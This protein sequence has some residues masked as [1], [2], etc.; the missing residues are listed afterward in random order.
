M[1]TTST[2]DRERREWLTS[3][4]KEVF[5]AYAAFVSRGGGSFEQ[6]RDLFHDALIVCYEKGRLSPVAQSDKAYLF[7]TAKHLW[8]NERKVQSGKTSTGDWNAAMD[9]ADDEQQPSQER[10][11]AFLESVGQKCLQ[12]LSA[13]YYDGTS[14]SEIAQKMG[15]SSKRSATVQKYKCIEKLRHQIKTKQRAYEDF[16]E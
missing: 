12:L 13:F 15:F 10:L 2:T 3:L 1:V 4:Y 6:A 9:T 5:P 16:F 11:L 7:G 8:L 14:L